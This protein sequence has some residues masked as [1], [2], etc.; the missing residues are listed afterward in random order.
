VSTFANYAIYTILHRDTL[1]R[2]AESG[3]MTPLYEK[4]RWVT[5]AELFEK[6]HRQGREMAIL[7][8]DATHC[9][10]LLYWGR[11]EA[12]E[13]SSNG[14]RYTVADLTPL[15]RRKTQELVLLS[16]NRRV[17]KGFIRPY[18]IVQTPSYIANRADP[19]FARQ[20]SGSRAEADSDVAQTNRAVKAGEITL[21]SFGYWGCGSAAPSL[22]KAID[23]AEIQRGFEPPLWVDVR[24]SRSVRAAG[25]RDRQ[26]ED[27]LRARHVWMPDLGNKRVQEGRK[28]IEIK[29]PAAAKELLQRALDRPTRRI[30]FFCSCEYPAFCHR[31]IVGQLVLK[32]AKERNAQVTV[33][34]WPGEEPGTLTIEVPPATLRQF[35]RRKR[36][37]TPI[38]PAMAVG[39]A[40]AL[41]WGTIATMHAGAEQAK[42]LVGPA[43]FNAAGSHLRVFPEEAGTRANSK[44]FRTEYGFARLK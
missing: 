17:A 2:I 31:K 19:H 6:A 22:V 10:R 44:A 28:G 25:F 18:A 12:I 23:E 29:N 41:P 1:N 7:Y 14:T 11:V 16:T 42:V 34:E 27:L 36:R 38:P 33:I 5:G 3:K 39:D 15:S 9:S 13:V 40:A 20:S 37:S 21:F 32:Y 35:E 8:A 24:I 30:I 26:F 43:S 4:K